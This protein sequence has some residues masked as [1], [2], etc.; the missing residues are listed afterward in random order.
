ME[1]NLEEAAAVQINKSITSAEKAQPAAE[2]PP[3]KAAKPPAEE[4]AAAET[5]AAAPQPAAEAPKPAEP[6]AEEP[7]AE[8][9][10]AAAP[11]PAA[12]APKPAEPAEPAAE[13]PAAEAPTTAPVAEEQDLQAL[14]NKLFNE[15]KFLIEKE[16]EL[17]K[18][19]KLLEYSR[20]DKHLRF[21]KIPKSIEN[22][23]K[24]LEVV[25]NGKREVF[26]SSKS[27]ITEGMSEEQKNELFKLL[28]DKLRELYLKKAIDENGIISQNKKSLREYKLNKISIGEQI[29]KLKAK[30]TLS[31]VE[32]EALENLEYKNNFDEEQ[33][34]ILNHSLTEARE[35]FYYFLQKADE[36]NKT[37]EPVVAKLPIKRVENSQ[38]VAELY[39][40]F[41]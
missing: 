29:R 14:A 17:F 30:N 11:Q 18:E 33:F 38:T 37:T 25:V 19:K 3:A 24:R 1:N 32:R 12:E 21:T 34:S 36:Y 40:G 8:A 13:E 28:Q 23:I 9:P 2:T 31:D 6:A 7:A 10:A 15:K 41:I 4:A 26:E 16:E 35:L 27:S 5:P 20:K 39:A 22:K